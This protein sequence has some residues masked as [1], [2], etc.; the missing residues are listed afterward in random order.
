[1][2]LTLNSEIFLPLSLKSRNWWHV[3]LCPVGIM[4]GWGDWP[5]KGS[6]HCTTWGP[7]VSARW[8]WYGSLWEAGTPRSKLPHRTGQ[9]GKVWVWLRDPASKNKADNNWRHLLML[10]LGLHMYVSTHVCW[11][12]YAHTHRPTHVNTQR[13]I[14]TPHGHIQKKIR[15]NSNLFIYYGLVVL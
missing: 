6:T 4:W 3:P 5:S 8:A 12:T 2:E 7:E 11:S 10:A 9:V 1:M 14:H 15:M 13:N